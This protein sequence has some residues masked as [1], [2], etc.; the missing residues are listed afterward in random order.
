MRNHDL[1]ENRTYTNP[2][3]PF[4]THHIPSTK[5]AISCHWHDEFEIIYIIKGKAIINVDS[6]QVVADEGT[7]V[8]INSDALHSAVAEKISFQSCAIVFNLNMLKGDTLDFCYQEYIEPLLKGYSKLP[9]IIHGKDVWEKRVLMHIQ[10]LIELNQCTVKGFEM[11]IKSCIYSL[12][13]EIIK[14]NKLEVQPRDEKAMKKPRLEEIKKVINYIQNNFARPLSIKELADFINL[15]EHH[16]YK[17]FKE[18][19]YKTPL[20]YINYY[21]IQKAAD[22]LEDSSDGIFNIAMDVGFSNYSYF[23]KTF[24]KYKN[25]TPYAYRK[26]A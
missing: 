1:K 6:T 10:N 26:K 4:S 7:A 23:I 12:L 17:I 13:F 8:L 20:D 18:I 19:T 25:Y 3:F 22:L 2:Y 16:F 15:S 24:K 5:H 9:L 11:G 14:N 21:R